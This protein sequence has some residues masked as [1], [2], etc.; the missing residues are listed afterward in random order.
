MI[1]KVDFKDHEHLP[2]QLCEGAE[3][4]VGGSSSDV[5]SV[6]Q[7]HCGGPVTPLCHHRL[8]DPF[9]VRRLWNPTFG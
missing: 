8:L 4:T 9:L 5:T 6:R 1:A 7:W 2:K 3:L